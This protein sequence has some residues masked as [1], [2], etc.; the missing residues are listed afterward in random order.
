MG[1]IVR[2]VFP[3]V[4]YL[5]VGT[6]ITIVAGCGFLRMNGTLDD[7]RVFRIL[8]LL[9]GVDLEEIAKTY[10]QGAGD[11][12]PEEA[13]FE[14][15]QDQ[16]QLAVLLRQG[17][18]DDLRKLRNDFDNKLERLASEGSR[19]EN[20]KDEV[21]QY[22]NQRKAEAI[23]SG[24]VGVRSQL[25]T[26]DPGRQAKPLLKQMLEDKQMDAVILL[27]NGMSA[28]NR[29]IILRTF[30]SEEEIEMLHGIQQQMLQGDPERSM[31]DKKLKE[32]NQGN[33]PDN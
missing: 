1:A 13:S 28:R 18:R 25:Q 7:E 26:L 6:V 21:D 16:I 27:L 23:D 8:S 19:F 5:C 14:Q 30:V 24:I 31:I 32:L 33:N 9:H 2:I 29:K 22:L 17:K 20:Y 15:R 10:E 3:L 4:G 12:P 11:V